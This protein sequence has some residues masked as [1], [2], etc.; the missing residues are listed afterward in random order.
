MGE[1]DRRKPPADVVGKPLGENDGCNQARSVCVTG[2]MIP[3]YD[4]AAG[5]RRKIQIQLFVLP[6]D[7]NGNIYMVAG[8]NK[9]GGRMASKVQIATRVDEDMLAQIKEIEKETRAD[10]A[11]VIR[12]LLDEGAK[13]YQLK[14]AIALL[15]DSK[16]TVSRAAEIAGMS[17]WDI[18]EV[19]RTKKI[20]IQYTVDDL[21]KS[22]ADS[23]IVSNS[24]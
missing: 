24:T 18:I 7:T 9:I 19:M 11:E 14:K 20:P 10:R 6:N 2:V 23:M 3:C 21:R 15:H 16:V 22:L 12:R 8:E 17:I 5:V 13:Q 1:H 4:A